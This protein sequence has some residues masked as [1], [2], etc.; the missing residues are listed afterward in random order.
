MAKFLQYEYIQGDDPDEVEPIEKE[1]ADFAEATYWLSKELFETASK[2]FS[3]E[4]IR[5]WMRYTEDILKVPYHVEKV[6][7]EA[8]YRFVYDPS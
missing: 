6:D 4:V 3:I 8:T 7:G 1:V 5:D 2:G